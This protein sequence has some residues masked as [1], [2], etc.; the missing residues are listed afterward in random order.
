VRELFSENLHDVVI[1]TCQD[2]DTTS[3][4]PIPNP[5]RLIVTRR[6]DPRL[7]GVEVD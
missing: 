5:D 6:N 2:G 7:F 3:V 1:V 4:L